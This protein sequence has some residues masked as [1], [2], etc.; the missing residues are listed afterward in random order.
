MPAWVLT[1]KVFYI[2]KTLE[3]CYLFKALFFLSLL[4]L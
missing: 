4:N 3:I 1:F 2:I